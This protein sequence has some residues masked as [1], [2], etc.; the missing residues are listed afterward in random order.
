MQT[1]KEY[2]QGNQMMNANAV[3]ACKGGKSIMRAGRKHENLKRKEYN[4]KCPHVRNL[5]NGGAGNIKLMGQP[6]M[7]ALQMYGMEFDP[8]TTKGIGNSG[9]EVH[10]IEDEEG[11]PVGHLRKKK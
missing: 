10:M 11:Q 3:S 9:V 6:L 1:F 2:Y 5:M 7:N 8:G 4:H